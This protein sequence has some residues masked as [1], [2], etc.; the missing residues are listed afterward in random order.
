MLDHIM[1][2]HSII[3]DSTLTAQGQ[4]TIP[5]AIREHLGLEPGDSIRFFLMDDHVQM[6]RVGSIQELLT[7]N[8]TEASESVSL[9]TMDQTIARGWSGQLTDD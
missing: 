4:T 2:D 7:M 5:K 1:S 9:D 3:K 8:Q 6:M